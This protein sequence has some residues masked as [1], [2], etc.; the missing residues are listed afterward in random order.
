MG[1]SNQRDY[2]DFAGTKIPSLGTS[3]AVDQ[4]AGAAFVGPEGKS[5]MEESWALQK[6]KRKEGKGKPGSLEPFKLMDLT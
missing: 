6:T 4:G 3:K 1:W 2:Q 5:A